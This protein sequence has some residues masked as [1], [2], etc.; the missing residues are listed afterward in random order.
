MT[1]KAGS[2]TLLTVKSSSSSYYFDF[3]IFL[4]LGKK[5]KLYSEVDYFISYSSS[6]VLGILFRPVDPPED[7]F[8][9]FGGILAW[10]F[11]IRSI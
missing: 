2:K 9:G 5:L 8:V 3:L 6:I 7:L 10:D 4:M 11:F 1:L